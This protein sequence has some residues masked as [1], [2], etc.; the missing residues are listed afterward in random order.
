MQEHSADSDSINMTSQINDVDS[1]LGRQQNKT[2]SMGL[3]VFSK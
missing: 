2:L 1:V 3:N